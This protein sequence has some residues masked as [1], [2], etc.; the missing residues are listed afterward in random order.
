MVRSSFENTLLGY[1]RVGAGWR[2]QESGEGHQDGGGHEEGRLGWDW[3]LMGE[4]RG[5]GA[6]QEEEA[7]PPSLSAVTELCFSHGEA[8]EE[9]RGGNDFFV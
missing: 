9:W 5:G 8:R 2:G 3:Q 1:L 7:I 4:G 6:W